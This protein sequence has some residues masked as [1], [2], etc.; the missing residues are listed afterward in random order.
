MAHFSH[1]GKDFSSYSDDAV[2]TAFKGFR[3]G[4]ALIGVIKGEF[5]LTAEQLKMLSHHTANKAWSLSWIEAKL[6][7]AIPLV[8]NQSATIQPT[9]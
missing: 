8:N 3:M 2:K 6:T 4:Y 5:L 7:D 1:A 9:S